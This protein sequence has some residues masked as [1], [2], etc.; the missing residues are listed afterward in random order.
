MLPIILGL[1]G[2][3][4]TDADR[5]RIDRYQPAGFILFTRN[6]VDAAQTRALTDELRERCEHS[7]LIGIDNEGGRVWRTAG[8]GPTPPNAALFGA[9]ATSTVAVP[10]TVVNRKRVC[11]RRRAQETW[12]DLVKGG[13]LSL[14]FSNVFGELSL[15][16]VHQRGSDNL[17]TA[18]LPTRMY[19]V[20][21]TGVQ[22]Y[23]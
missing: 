13:L 2:P 11:R 4:L 19:A 1:D 5:D 16:I 21:F 15:L 18:Q 7:P 22:I 3:T 20:H 9:K 14:S 12:W 6:I 17:E 23:C 10:T 8:L